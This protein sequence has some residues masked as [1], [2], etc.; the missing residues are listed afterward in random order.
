MNLL[1]A[2]ALCL[3]S[4]LV[5]G[6]C[7]ESPKHLTEAVKT[8]APQSPSAVV[9]KSAIKQGLITAIHL[10][11]FFQLQ[12][13]NKALIFDARPSFFYH[14]GHVPGAISWPRSSFI[15]QFDLHE[16]QILKAQATGKPVVIYCTDLACPDAMNVAERLAHLGYSTAILQGGWAAWK[17]GE[18]PIE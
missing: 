5:L 4:A 13:T 8:S 18:L 11:T 2:L 16:Q 14:L 3:I 9:K 6:S 10:G 12:Q 7:A 1:R 17:S 15:Q